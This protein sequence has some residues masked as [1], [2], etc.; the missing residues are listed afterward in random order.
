MNTK[1]LLK[2]MTFEEKVGQMMQIA[3]F[4][5]IEH[6]NVEVFGDHKDLGLTKEEIF[7]TGSVLGIGNATEM[8]TVQE[9]YLKHNRLGIPLM[10]MADIVH[11]YETIFPVP[12]ALAS[13]FNESLVYQASRIA[14]I[15]ASTAGIH[16]TFAPMADLVRDPRWGRVVESFG[17]DPYLNEVLTKSSVL[18]FQKDNLKDEDSVA[19]CIK[20]FAGYGASEAGRDY[21]TVDISRINLH[22]MYFSGYRRG[23]E[24]GAKLV[25]TSFNVIEGIPATVS[26]FLLKDIL[27]DLWHFKGVSISDY[28]SLHQILAH[29]C[30]ENDE[31]AAERGIVAGL[32]IEMA[33]NC[34]IRN[35]KK[36]VM[37]NKVPIEL[38]DEAVLRIL[39]L[40]NEVGLF[41]NPYKGAS[42]KREEQLV[43]SKEHLDVAL[44][45]AKESIVLLENNGIL[46]LSKNLKIAIVGPYATSKETNGPWSWHG[47]NQLNKSLYE[48][49]IDLEASILVAISKDDFNT[50]THEEINKIKESDVVIF[51]LGEHFRESGEAHSK[52]H[53]RLSDKQMNLY[54]EIK[55]M[56]KKT[57]TIVTAGRPLILKELQ[58]SDAL[59]YT[60]FLGSRHSDAVSRMLLGYDNPSG[61]LPMSFPVTE[62]QIP[63]YYNYLNTG[64]PYQING[65]NEYTSHYLDI[66][67]EPLYTFGDGISYTTYQYSDL[68]INQNH[69]FKNDTVKVSV[70]IK[71]I[72]EMKGKETVMLFIRDRVAFISRPVMELKKFK[73]IELNPHETK[74]I[75][76]EISA[77][78]LLYYDAAGKKVLEPGLF[79]IMVGPS[80]NKTRS[81]K[82]ELKRGE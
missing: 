21:N 45:I 11:G 31:E 62:G 53:I 43:R 75:T 14:A 68:S 78:D 34:Y 15:E 19:S 24:S 52:A 25:M 27:R 49:M 54:Q 23:V 36:L 67:N 74:Q 37:E 35:L 20:H 69:M 82:L 58:T 4:F 29:G 46:P 51:A 40:K 48:S 59:V 73:K 70:D 76:F 47:N 64:R 2:E 6:A 30:A 61:K 56:S 42:L 7:H 71:N 5:F 55:K 3:P 8:K 44:D 28:D 10:F 65:H 33:S 16:V 41:D 13:T 72:G 38:I 22:N 17:E 57:V 18:G 63:I 80:A 79:D 50:Y 81:L 60:W 12:I 32:D 66:S 77:D 9:L 39:D 1:K 26:S